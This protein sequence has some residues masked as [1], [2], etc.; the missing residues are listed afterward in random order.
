MKPI[1]MTVY[2]VIDETQDNPH[3]WDVAEWLGTSDVVGWDITDGHP[4]G[5]PGCVT[6][7]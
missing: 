5:C 7:D 1:T 6:H 3:K 4:Q 2:M